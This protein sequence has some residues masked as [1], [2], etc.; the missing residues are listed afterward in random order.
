MKDATTIAFLGLGQM[1]TPMAANLVRAGFRVRVWNPTACGV[2]E[3]AKLGAVPAA[4]PAD[5]TRGADVMITMLE[6]GAAVDDAM[7]RPGG[8]LEDA[9]PGQ[10][11]VQ[12]S[13][14]GVDWTRHLADDAREFGVT[15][16][17][18][19]VSGDESLA[20]AGELVILASGSE[21]VRRTLAPVFGALG[22]TAWLGETG[23]GT[24]ATLVLN[25][26]KVDSMEAPES[27]WFDE[28]PLEGYDTD[29][30]PGARAPGPV[31]PGVSLFVPR[32]RDPLW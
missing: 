4:V 11:W 8:G 22:R 30:A 5:A 23:A 7:F 19:P 32:P 18:A 20:T 14:V 15:Y 31:P 9:K 29:P 21:H 6:D 25:H 13:T 26:L 27:L 24:R 17:D 10:V 16:V 3:L 12:M 28:E 1:G 2:E